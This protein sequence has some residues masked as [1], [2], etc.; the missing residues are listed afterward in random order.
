MPRG[1]VGFATGSLALIA[2][3]VALKP[4]SAR[5][6]EAGGGVVVEA[7]RRALSP[8]V[9]GVPQRRV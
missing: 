6:A 1:L 4:G 7:L 3:Y 9:A 2:L 5:A 8:D